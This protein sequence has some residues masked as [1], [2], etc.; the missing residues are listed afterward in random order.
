MHGPDC[1]PNRCVCPRKC[2]I[3]YCKENATQAIEIRGF[4]KQFMCDKHTQL[5]GDAIAPSYTYG[6]ESL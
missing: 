4:F 3:A 5:L 1:T 6:V 2:G